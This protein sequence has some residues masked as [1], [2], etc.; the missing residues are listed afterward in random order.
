VVGAVVSINGTVTGAPGGEV[1]F[2]ANV[3]NATSVAQVTQVTL[4]SGANTIGVP[5]GAVGCFFVPYAGNVQA[6]T[7]K[8]VSGDT[9]VGLHPTNPA[10]LSFASGVTSFVITAGGVTGGVSELY[11][12]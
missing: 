12:F 9:G 5:S 3:V 1:G 11:F 10:V 8:G 4:A 6:L 7:L 2:G